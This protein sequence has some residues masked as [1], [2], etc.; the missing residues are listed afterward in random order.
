VFRRALYLAQLLH[1]ES[2][3]PATLVAHQ[4]RALRDLVHYAATQV[5]FYRDIYARCGVDALSFRG[6]AD[7]A[8][9]P[10][11]DKAMLRSAG[12][13]AVAL[14][15]PAQRVRIST[16]GSTGEPFEF[17]IDRRYDQWRKAQYLRPYLRNGRRLLDKVLR[18]TA[19]PSSRTPWFS[20]LGLLREWQLSCAADPARI[21]AAWRSLAPDVLQGY[22]SSLRSLAHY[23]LDSG[24]S[25]A[26]APRLLF[27]DSELLSPDARS[28]LEK[29][30]G[31]AVIDIFGTYE[32]DNIAYQCAAREGY[33][34]ATDCV[35]LE[36]VRD[37]KPVAP[38]QEGEL[39][40]SV[41][42]N[43]TTPF[44]RYNLHDLGRLS[45][46]PC[47]CGSPFPLLQTLAG[48][49]DDLIVLADG[50]RRSPMAVLGRLDG[51]VDAIL[52]YQ[53]RQLSVRRF[54][55]LIAPSA[56]F[57]E[58]G[59]Q[60]IATA[61]NAALDHPQLDVKLVAAFPPHPSGKLRAFVCELSREHA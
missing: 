13:G 58:V 14:G 55:L 30:F 59:T 9:L 6:L 45:D 41:L 21:V 57:A 24:E 50:S 28:L 44:I 56:R 38:G 3:P 29:V 35:V 11:I 8:Q 51:F 61:V 27:T 52:H 19:F 12:A 47:R 53:L 16:S 31:A 33:H 40:V 7:L 39:V 36:L 48:R 15:A 49:A 46:T 5:P 4:D 10:I 34:V 54:E 37:G 1:N 2:L 22:P 60:A 43:H 25:L 17:R 18:L 20:R 42:A 32:T 26:P 23:C